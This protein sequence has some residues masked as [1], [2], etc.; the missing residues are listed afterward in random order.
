MPS[1]KY[2]GIAIESKLS[3]L[4]DHLKGI[5]T[6]ITCVRDGDKVLVS[7]GRAHY[8]WITSLVEMN[9]VRVQTWFVNSSYQHNNLVFL[10]NSRSE[11]HHPCNDASIVAFSI[12]NCEVCRILV[13]PSSS[14]NV[15]IVIINIYDYE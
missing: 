15:L 14:I 4:K 2:L 3:S 7:K 10:G 9:Q 8:S 1:N 11:V 13:D 5:V 6:V 12:A